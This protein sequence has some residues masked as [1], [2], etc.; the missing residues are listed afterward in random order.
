M[1][2]ASICSPIVSPENADEYVNVAMNLSL[3]CGIILFIWG[4]L[5]LGI[6][7]S[8]L[9]D[10]ILNAFTTA[11]AFNI[12]SSQFK[13]LFGLSKY[14]TKRGPFADQ[15]YYLFK[16]IQYTNIYA[17][18]ISM[19]SLVFIITTKRLNKKY[20]KRIPIPVELI[21]VIIVTS[22]SAGINF[23]KHFDIEILH[24]IPSGLPPLKFPSLKY[25]SQLIVPGLTLS[26]II[27]AVGIS[28]GKTFARQFGYRIDPNQELI[29][30]GCAN[31]VG[32]C[33]AAY[34]AA[35]SLSRSAIA[36][37]MGALTP[38]HNMFSVIIIALALLFF[39]S[40]LYSLP[41]AVLGA[42]VVAA[43][44]KLI[45]Q[46]VDTKILYKQTRIEFFEYIFCFIMTCVFDTQIGLY[47]GL[48]LS[49]VA[50]IGQLIYA[51]G[52]KNLWNEMK[53]IVNIEV[54]SQQ[55]SECTII[56]IKFHSCLYY[57][58]KEIV[59]NKIIKSFPTSPTLIKYVLDFTDC[60]LID[61]S[62]MIMITDLVK[63]M[64]EKNMTVIETGSSAFLKQQ[65]ILYNT[66]F[67]PV[68]L[69]NILFF[70]L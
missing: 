68:Y 31:I 50:M 33:V 59:F 5:R 1:M 29:A 13:Y 49:F 35:G 20:C 39:T 21:I 22:L 46:L 64:V 51:S 3:V 7:T 54:V 47:S 19:T 66:T 8:L 9:S 67:S 43:F 6:I 10:P 52:I 25:T 4:I 61:N 44:E 14:M 55:E 16:S 36:A 41:Q 42:I 34:P 32:C 57:I 28:I 27:Y 38:L 24:G 56:T 70:I 17:L 26:L 15:V 63:T 53:N 23:E 40:L 18:I 48:G 12:A 45:L 2:V 11:S 30:G 69:Y 58:N 37:S 62:A 65:F 60:N